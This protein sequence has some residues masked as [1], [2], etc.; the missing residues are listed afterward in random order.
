M[1]LGAIPVAHAHTAARE[2]S[3]QAAEAR[4]HRKATD[5]GMDGLAG[6]RVSAA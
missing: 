1:G 6:W 5:N 3:L 2:R 4:D